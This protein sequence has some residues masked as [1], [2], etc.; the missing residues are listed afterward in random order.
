MMIYSYFNRSYD[1]FCNF[2]L[3]YFKKSQICRYSSTVEKIPLVRDSSSK[4]SDW[5][6]LKRESD[7]DNEY[8]I[9]CEASSN[10]SDYVNHPGF[11]KS[12]L[13]KSKLGLKYIAQL[14]VSDI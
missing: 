11:G 4:R 10:L 8:K 12:Q 14:Q 1:L 7:L 5:E 6:R 9:D 13:P 2:T 3:G